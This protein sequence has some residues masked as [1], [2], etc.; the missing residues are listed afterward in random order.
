[1]LRPAFGR[2]SLAAHR[3]QA[4]ALGLT[5]TEVSRPGL[6]FDLDTPADFAAYLVAEGSTRGG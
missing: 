4:L 1:M 2:G 5:V 6:A 3:R